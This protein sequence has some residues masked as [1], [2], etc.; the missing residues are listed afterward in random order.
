MKLKSLAVALI[1]AGAASQSAFA[2]ETNVALHGM[3]RSGTLYN[4][5]G[6]M[7]KGGAVRFANSGHYFSFGNNAAISKIQI[8]PVVTYTADDGVYARA[9]LLWSQEGSDWNDQWNSTDNSGMARGIVALGGFDWNPSTEF[10]AG[11]TKD[12]NGSVFTTMYDT[13]VT[14]EFGTGAGFQNMDIGFA[15]WDATLISYDDKASSKA[16]PYHDRVGGATSHEAHTWLHAI[17]GTGLDVQLKYFNVDTA[18]KDPAQPG[19]K[20][21]QAEEGYGVTVVYN[22]PG[23]FWFGDGFA[24]IAFQYGKGAGALLYGKT[25]D[26]WDGVNKDRESLRLILDGKLDLTSDLS[27]L[28]FAYFMHE[29]AVGPTSGYY[30]GDLEPFNKDRNTF[31]IGVRP[32]YQ[33]TSHFSIHTEANYEHISVYGQGWSENEHGSK[34]KW[35]LTLS[36][37]L[38]LGQGVWGAPT[39][40]AFIS[41]AHWNEGAAKGGTA[42]TWGA[43]NLTKADST[44]DYNNDVWMFG[45]Q[46]EAY[47]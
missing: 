18:Y 30:T 32:V 19:E 22:T 41:Y 21:Y 15:K 40:R 36:P 47:F 45:F 34:D 23:Y 17:G 26:A 43:P 8:N 2:A 10:W 37:T 29:H 28:T 42:L 3:V 13:G 44:G 27:M 12:Q 24:K 38:S 35:Q 31:A 33:I 20:P 4:M 39:V 6:G 16:Y 25:Q 46:G 9:D 14:E 1:F 11:R 5:N 7:N